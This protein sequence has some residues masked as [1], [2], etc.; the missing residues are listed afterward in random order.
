VDPIDS[1]VL[2]IGKID[3]GTVENIIPDECCIYGT[4]RTL[5]KETQDYMTEGLKRISQHVAEAHLCEA[6]YIHK[7]GY[8]NTTNSEREARFMGE[9]GDGGQRQRL[10][11][12]RSRHDGRGFRLHAGRIPGAYGWI[13][14]G[15]GGQP[16]GLHNPG[17]DF[18][19]DNIE[20]GA[21]FWDRL[22]RRWFT[23]PRD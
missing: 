13:G 18:N 8:P 6:T 1:A 19:D 17:Y 5:S 22:A 10:P 4:V 21:R 14:N 16:G 3:G 15:K 7:P 12:H 2:T 11:R 9:A 20:L 23:Q